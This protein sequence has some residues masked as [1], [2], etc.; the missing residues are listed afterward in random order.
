MEFRDLDQ[1]M[2]HPV[3]VIIRRWH[4]LGLSA[5]LITFGPSGQGEGACPALSDPVPAWGHQTQ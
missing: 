5:T 3:V 1:D 2:F 4:R